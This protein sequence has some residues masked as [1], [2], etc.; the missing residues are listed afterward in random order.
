MNGTDSILKGKIKNTARPP[1]HLQWVY[2]SRHQPLFYAFI[3][4]LRLSL[5]FVLLFSSFFL[6]VFVST[7][8]PRIVPQRFLSSSF[9]RTL[10]ISPSAVNTVSVCRNPISAHVSGVIQYHHHHQHRRG[11]IRAYRFKRAHADWCSHRNTVNYYQ[12]WLEILAEY[13]RKSF[14]YFAV[15]PFRSSTRIIRT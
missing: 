11:R 8:R 13:M 2:R 12:N 7:I 14:F 10:F 9:P 6:S 15:F 4:L 1:F 5:R 3:T